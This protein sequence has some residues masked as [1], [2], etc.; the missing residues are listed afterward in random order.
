[1]KY[2]VIEAHRSEYPMPI[3]FAVGTLLDIGQRYAGEHDWQDWYLCRCPGQ[4]PGWV[5]AQIIQ[6]LGV[7]RGRA[8]EAYNAHELDIDPGQQVEGLRPLNGWLWCRRLRNGEL[9]WL[10]QAKLRQVA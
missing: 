5:P 10:P 2:V 7:G 9:G 4:A 3:T 1:M 8:L 6:C